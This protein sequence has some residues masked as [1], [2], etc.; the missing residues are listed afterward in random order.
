M[1]GAEGGASR[2]QA[3]ALT[4]WSALGHGREQRRVFLLDRTGIFTS[5]EI[6][7]L[8]HGM[9]PFLMTLGAFHL[10]VYQAL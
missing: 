5:L 8:Y 4:P 1:Q 7:V 10:P 3:M 2:P 9:K 6:I